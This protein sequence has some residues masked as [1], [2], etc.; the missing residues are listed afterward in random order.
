MPAGE[1]KRVPDDR[2]SVLKGSFPSCLFTDQPAGHL[3][4]N[5]VYGQMSVWFYYCPFQHLV[6]IVREC[7]NSWQSRQLC[8]VELVGSTRC[9]AARVLD[10]YQPCTENGTVKGSGFTEVFCVAFYLPWD[11]QEWRFHARVL[12]VVSLI[13]CGKKQKNKTK[14]TG[15]HSG[16]YVLHKCCRVCH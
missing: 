8:C 6:E 2:S 3:S 7:L 5:P 13:M 14:K 4:A 12:S 10:C 11:I 16:A 15:R 1:R 9:F